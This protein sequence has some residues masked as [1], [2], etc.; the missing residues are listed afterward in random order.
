MNLFVILS[1]KSAK[2]FGEVHP[3]LNCRG[4]FVVLYCYFLKF[5]LVLLCGFLILLCSYSL[6]IHS[7]VAFD[8]F[9]YRKLF[10]SPT[11]VHTDKMPFFDYFSR[12][13]AGNFKIYWNKNVHIAVLGEYIL[14]W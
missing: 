4:K 7:P 8:N 14:F 1:L 11:H 6:F 13:Y 10:T 2:I 12:F 9:V 5:T 3:I